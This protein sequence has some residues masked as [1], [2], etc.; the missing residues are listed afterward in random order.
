LEHVNRATRLQHSLQILATFKQIQGFWNQKKYVEQH[1][2][3]PVAC[4]E[5]A[6][7]LS[8]PVQAYREICRLRS[9]ISKHKDKPAKAS[10]VSEW[11]RIKGE[12]ERR[13]K[14]AA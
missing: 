13:L 10:E 8:D 3:L 14:D 2:V 4:A 6:K 7:D 5:F 1:G 12:L 9:R 11:I